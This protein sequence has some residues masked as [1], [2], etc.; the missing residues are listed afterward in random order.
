V[1]LPRNQFKL[2]LQEGRRQLG[3]WLDLASPLSA[4]ICAGAGFDW[5]VIDAEHGPNDIGT[6]LAQLQALAAYPAQAIVR[7]PQGDAVT[8]K[9]VLDV[10]AQTILVPLV[11]TPGQATQLVAAMRYPPQGVRGVA[12]AIVRASRWNR[13]PDYLG[14]A[15]AEVC[16]VVQV[17]TREGL[18]NL[19]GIAAVEGVDAIFIGPA[20]LA[21]SIGHLGNAKHPEVQKAVDDAIRRIRKAGKPAGIL[22]TEDALIRR[23]LEL[24]CSFVGIGLDAALLATATAELVTKYR[25]LKDVTP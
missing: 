2:A 19:E 8:I 4:E 16:L 20:D 3:F 12:S 18:A 1:D 25:A 9:R 17:E 10:G 14:K 22:A 24:G 21:A 11:E 15:N 7:V 5:L 6:V 13:I 23:Y